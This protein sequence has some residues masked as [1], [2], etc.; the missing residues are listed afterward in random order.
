MVN[1]KVLCGLGWCRA[2]L[3]VLLMVVI[4]GWVLDIAATYLGRYYYN[5]QFLA[6][7]AGLAVAI[8]LLEG[9]TMVRPVWF[10][11]LNTGFTLVVLSLFVYV[12]VRFPALQLE[13]ASAPLNAVVMGFFMLIGVMEAVRRKTGWFLPCLVVFLVGFAFVGPHLP[14]VYQTRPVSFSR[15]MVYL[16]LDTNAL[17]SQILAIAAIVVAPF[18]VFGYLLNNFGGSAVFSDLAA[19]AVGRYKG[20]PAK[21]SVVGSGAFG[22]VSGSAVANV[23]AVGSVTIP[24]MVRAGYSRHVAGSIEAVAS[25]GGQLIPPIMGA[26][27]FLMAELLQIPYRT[28]ALAAIVPSLLFYL[29]LLLS[30][31]FEA[32]R[33]NIQGDPNLKLDLDDDTIDEVNKRHRWR[34]LLPAG[35]LIYFLFWRNMSPEIAGIYSTA[36]LL[37]VHFIWPWQGLWQRIQMAAFGLVRAMGPISDIIVLAGAAGLVIGILN[38]TGVAF[39]ITIQMLAISGGVLAILLLLTAI[40]SIILGLGMPTVGV[41]VLLATLAAPALI[42]LGVVPVA[43]HLYVLYF[44]MLSMITPPIAIASFAAASVANTSPWRTAFA[45]LKVG[46]GI[47]LIPVAF[48]LQPELLMLGSGGDLLLAAAR[49]AL[50]IALLSAAAVGHVVRP[51]V[52][53]ARIGVGLLALPNVLSFGSSVP[54]T[55]LWLIA[56]MGTAMMVWLC[57][58]DR[59]ES[60]KVGAMEQQ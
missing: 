8:V 47:Y 37:I 43:A 16:S 50:A 57:W 3:S 9:N 32:R 55:L 20:G 44:G 38:L 2:G 6:L 33:L 28:V 21:V 26:S 52:W 35:V 17:L 4:T 34:Y 41:Y 7:A 40:L 5:E 48:V 59:R 1:P 39:A 45:S 11:A 46:A 58:P 25:T 56:A 19:K 10:V 29:A 23:V 18:I 30:V 12:A 36:S 54:D 51:L 42:Q 49:C 15:I 22:M 27:A 53:Q 14:A 13:V 60:V 31:D 24:T